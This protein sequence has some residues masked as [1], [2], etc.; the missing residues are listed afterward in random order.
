MK[1][2]QNVSDFSYLASEPAAAYI[3]SATSTDYQGADLSIIRHARKGIKTGYLLQ[4][5]DLMGLTQIEISK[6]LHVSLR[7]LQRYDHDFILDSD[8]SSKVIQLGM[9]YHRGLDVIGDQLGFSD[10]L[11]SPMSSLEGRSPLDYLDTPFGFQLINQIL[12]RIE[13]GVFA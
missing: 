13:H 10:W 7:T 4:L 3:S 1:K 2:Y 6:I 8:A 12:G 11:K 9:L 5:G